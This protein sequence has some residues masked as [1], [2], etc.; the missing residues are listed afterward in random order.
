MQDYRKYLL[1]PVA[2]MFLFGA[3]SVMA[4]TE[5]FSATADVGGAA[6]VMTDFNSTSDAGKDTL[7]SA[8]APVNEDVTMYFNAKV[9]DANDDETYF[10]VCKAEGLTSGNCT[11]AADFICISTTSTTTAKQCSYTADSVSGGDAATSWVAYAYAYDGAL[12]NDNNSTTT[13]TNH[14]PTVGG[15][16]SIDEATVYASGTMTVNIGSATKTDADSGDTTAYY[17]RFR[18]T[19][20]ATVLQ[21]WSTTST[22]DC[23]SDGG[24]TGNGFCSKS[25]TVYVDVRAQDSH[26]LYG[27]GSE[28]TYV[29]TTKDITNSAPVIESLLIEGLD[30][31]A[32]VNPVEGTT[33]AVNV[34]VLVYDY[35]RTNDATELSAG[36]GWANCTDSYA[37]DTAFAVQ[38]ENTTADWLKYTGLTMNYNTAGGAKTVTTYV[39]D[40]T[41]ADSDSDALESFTY[42]TI[43]VVQ[44]NDS[45]LTFGSV[46]PGTD[47]NLGTDAQQMSNLGNGVIDVNIQGAD[48]AYLTNTWE[49]ANFSVDDDAIADE[50]S[51]NLANMTLTAAPQSFHD[52]GGVAVDGTFN[53]W[54]FIDAPLGLP[55]GTYTSTANW[56]WVSEQHV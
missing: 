18:D 56:E 27:D 2:L 16:L 33:T 38:N 28:E 20:D 52:A 22:Y 47:E 11:N 6:P 23:T 54:Y 29:E 44:L 3:A 32:S 7:V 53:V 26:G 10:V 31:G 9:T 41:T 48:L 35:D 37:A 5:T 13:Y 55:A 25:D 50:D 40:K 34:T 36:T 12:T 15:T 21:D 46:T 45:S 49:I 39:Y 43:Y 8:V 1:L 17:Y 4:E 30:S 24:G 42:N 19:D 14:A 51:G